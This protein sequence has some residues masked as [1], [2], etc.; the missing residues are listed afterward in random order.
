MSAQSITLDG[1]SIIYFYMDIL[2]TNLRTLDLLVNI[3]SLFQLRNVPTWT[4]LLLRSIV[5]VY[6]R[7]YICNETSPACTSPSFETFHRYIIKCRSDDILK[8]LGQYCTNWQTVEGVRDVWEQMVSNVNVCVFQKH[9]TM[10]WNIHWFYRSLRDTRNMFKIT[11]F[12]F[13]NTV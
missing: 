6:N 5:R 4:H 2:S 12:P 13:L 10:S 9:S 1:Q 7:V 3:G 8:H 11:G